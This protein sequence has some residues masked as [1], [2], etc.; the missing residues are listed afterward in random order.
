[1]AISLCNNLNYSLS[2]TL[3]K[4]SLIMNMFDIGLGITIFIIVIFIVLMINRGIS[5]AIRY[6]GIG[7]DT[8]FGLFLD[9]LGLYYLYFRIFRCPYSVDTI[10]GQ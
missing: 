5:K 9:S 1:M 4:V 3:F 8:L 2:K 10:N 6:T 7:L